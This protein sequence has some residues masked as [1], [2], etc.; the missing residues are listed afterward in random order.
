MSLTP[1]PIV[2][3]ADVQ[4]FVDT[5]LKDKGFARAPSAEAAHKIALD[6]QQAAQQTRGYAEAFASRVRQR[7]QWMKPSRLPDQSSANVTERD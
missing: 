5:L 7:V 6:S 3:D 2:D 4:R 1:N